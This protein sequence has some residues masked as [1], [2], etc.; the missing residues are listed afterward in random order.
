MPTA[1]CPTLIKVIDQKV[2]DF[3]VAS[4]FSYIKEGE[5]FVFCANPELIA[6]LQRQFAKE[7]Y[8]IESKLRF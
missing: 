6:V 4:G 3:L 5:T 7:Q 8:I 2:S 1:N